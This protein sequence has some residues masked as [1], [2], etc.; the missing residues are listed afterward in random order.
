M[1]LNIA[2]KNLVSNSIAFFCISV[3][4]IIGI[5]IRVM[6]IYECNRGYHWLPDEYY[7]FVSTAENAFNGKGFFPGFNDDFEMSQGG[8]LVPPPMQAFFIFIIYK[9][10]GSIIN[11]IIPRLV[12]AFLGGIMI[13]AGAA[14]GFLL[15]LPLAGIIIALFFAI[16]PEFIFHAEILQTESN[17]LVGLSILIALL[18]CW[19]KTGRTRW[20]WASAILIGCLTLQRSLSLLLPFVIAA[21]SLY[22]AKGRQKLFHTL[23]F[24]LVP[25][26]VISPWFARNLAIYGEPIL[27]GS[28]DGIAF[29]AANNIKLDPLKTPY[30]F[31]E[32]LK[33][34]DYN[35]YVP[36]IEKKYRKN[37]GKKFITNNE[38]TLMVSW[39]QYSEAYK[40]EAF[41][42]IR[43]HPIH[44]LKNLLFKTWNQFWLVQDLPKKAVRFFDDRKKFL[45]L[46]RILL[47]G[48]GLGFL[49]LFSQARRKE[50]LL[51]IV[52]FTYFSVILSLNTLDPSGRYNI[53][54]KLFLIIFFSCGCNIILLK[55]ALK[56]ALSKYD[57]FHA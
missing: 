41:N 21:L 32:I 3:I 43:K 44:F 49:I 47:L 51:I 45:F 56:T 12:Q 15:N 14:M 46:H 25:Y 6:W 1:K 35:I 50:Y 29:Y 13:L 57:E 36:S 34:P 33:N 27:V 38:G 39:Y 53:Y 4:A 31:F 2:N 30:V 55:Y 17:Y 5:W 54:L 23:I 18:I 20:A 24:L 11:P 40:I 9:I 7:Y 37:D 10:A 52:M 16:Y 42:Y 19:A 8:V 48:G 26:C 28:L 22:I